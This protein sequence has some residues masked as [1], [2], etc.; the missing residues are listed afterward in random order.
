MVTA[1]DVKDR[2]GRTL[3]TA[4]HTITGQNLKTLKS[5]GVTEVNIKLQDDAKNDPQ[6]GEDPEKKIPPAI[7]K[8]QDGLFRHTDRRHPAIAELYDVC[9]TRKFKLMQEGS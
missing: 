5:W 1:T 3:L 7:V 8:E 9:L 2:M 4:G 6:K